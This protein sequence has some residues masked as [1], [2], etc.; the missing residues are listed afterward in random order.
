[1]WYGRFAT[2]SYGGSTQ[3]DEVLVERVAL[4]QAEGVDTLEPIAQEGR[5]AADRARPR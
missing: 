2:T 5:Q 1:M 4:D 3:V